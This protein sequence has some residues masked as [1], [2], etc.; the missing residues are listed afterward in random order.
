MPAIPV[1]QLRPASPPGWLP[2][3]AAAV[4]AWNLLAVLG[5][6]ASYGDARH[7]VVPA[8]FAATLLRFVVVHLPLSAVSLVLA[9]GFDRAGFRRQQ[10]S[11]LL[12]AYGAVLLVFLPLLSIWH[13]AINNLFSGRPLAALPVLLGQQSVLSWWFDALVLTL[14]F[15]AHL[16]YGAWRHGQAQA[17]AW[18]LARQGNLA[19]RLRLLQGQLEPYFLSSAL[20][21]IGQLNREGLREQAT[22]ALVRLSGLLRYALRASR[23]DWQ[24]VA[25]EIEFL[26]DYVDLQRLCHG[27]GLAVQWQ[28]GDADWAD[29]RCPPLLLFPMLE[30]ALATQPQRLA[31]HIVTQRADGGPWVLAEVS[32][33]GGAHSAR[34]DALAALAERLAMLYGDAA[35]LASQTDGDTIHIRLSYP[36][37]LH[38]D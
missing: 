10:L 2:P 8:A 25:D 11:Q 21:G 27:A 14:A 36:V 23:S 12:L 31:V 20:A 4:L 17:L 30:R 13:S 19:L 15:G 32:Y 29:Y 37:S 7:A 38:D 35:T 26:R 9:V 33:A 1:M 5:A 28:L 18:Q 22:R 6:L 34:S 3:W 16:A 24:S